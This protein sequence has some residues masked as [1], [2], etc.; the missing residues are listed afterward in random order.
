MG[1]LSGWGQLCL[2]GIVRSGNCPGGVQ[3]DCNYL[4]VIY[5]RWEFSGSNCLGAVAIDEIEGNFPRGLEFLRYEIELQ[6][7]V[8]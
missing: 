5:A 3:W 8:T 1:Q 6:N 2:V 7:R 4:R